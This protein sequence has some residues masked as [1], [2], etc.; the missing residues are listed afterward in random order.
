MTRRP[1]TAAT[2]V[3]APAPML[4]ENID[5]HPDGG[6]CKHEGG[7]DD[8]TFIRDA[9]IMGQDAHGDDARLPAPQPRPE[10]LKS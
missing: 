3:E 9:V 8:A 2:E 10:S 7:C 6:M 1:M 4:D 5:L